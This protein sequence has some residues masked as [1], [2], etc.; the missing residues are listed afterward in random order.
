[1]LCVERHIKY[2]GEYCG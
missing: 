1:M 2:I